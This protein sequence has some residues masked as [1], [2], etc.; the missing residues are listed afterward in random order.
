[1]LLARVEG[2]A[3]ATIKH[4]SLTGWRMA[5]VQPLDRYGRDVDFPTIAIDSLGVGPGDV[6]IITSDGKGVREMVGD[7]QSPVRWFVFGIVDQGMDT[8]TQFTELAAGA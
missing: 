2:K 5:I 7:S 1:M 6:V 8:F 3:I 4:P